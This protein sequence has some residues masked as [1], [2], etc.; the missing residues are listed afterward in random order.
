[1][2]DY[3]S[4][5][6]A[7]EKLM[8]V[9]DRIIPG[10]MTQIRQQKKQAAASAAIGKLDAPTMHDPSPYD[11]TIV[12]E[13]LSYDVEAFRELCQM[14]FEDHEQMLQEAKR[15]LAAG[16]SSKVASIAHTLKGVVGNFAAPE[17]SKAAQAFY[18]AAKRGES[19][20]TAKA[21]DR[22]QKQLNRLIEA[23]KKDLILEAK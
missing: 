11:R 9:I 5:P 8:A 3:I 17:A 4:K 6:V 10:N 23:I 1:M 7:V 22:F 19:A 14:L 13:S 21:L 15:A 16:D 2:N 12:M 20:K 18:D